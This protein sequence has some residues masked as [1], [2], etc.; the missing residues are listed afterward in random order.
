VHVIASTTEINKVG[1]DKHLSVFA[2]QFSECTSN[3]DIAPPLCYP[4]AS[5]FY[6]VPCMPAGR[7]QLSEKNR[8]RHNI[9]QKLR[10]CILAKASLT[11][12]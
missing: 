5:F 7:S 6:L 11:E 3:S 8:L 2:S 4:G 10:T 12:P 9:Q 1:P